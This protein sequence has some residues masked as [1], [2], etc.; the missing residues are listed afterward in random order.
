MTTLEQ[1][2]TI[3]TDEFCDL[4]EFINSLL[5]TYVAHHEL[6]SRHIPHKFILGYY[7]HDE[8]SG[9]GDSSLLLFSSDKIDPKTHS[10]KHVWI[11]YNNTIYDLAHYVND[12]LLQV[13]PVDRA[14]AKYYNNTKNLYTINPRWK[15]ADM[16]N[17]EDRD[18]D[19]IIDRLFTKLLSCND[20]E[21]INNM[22]KKYADVLVKISQKMQYI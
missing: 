6:T 18:Y 16:D 2:F 15:R 3:I 11:E 5:I 21:Y 10:Y 8:Q 19:V 13:M 20:S 9:P 12:K 17:Q 22:P 14:N 1:L 7:N 4:K